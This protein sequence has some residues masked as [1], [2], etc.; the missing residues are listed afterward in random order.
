M[1]TATPAAIVSAAPAQ[2]PKSTLPGVNILIEGPTGTGKTTSLA[3][4]AAAGLEVFCLFTESGLESLLGA[5]KDYGKEIPPNVHWHI[6]KKPPADFG[7]MADAAE[8]VNTLALEALAK[9]SDPN[10]SKHNQF[11]DLPR[12]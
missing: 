6:L 10:R 9:M 4:L 8:K 11:I 5:W 3:T 1:S 7:V 12:S 2:S